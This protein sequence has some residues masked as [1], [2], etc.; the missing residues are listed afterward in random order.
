MFAA[1]SSI[2]LL[3]WSAVDSS[4]I[5]PL[6]TGRRS[7]S[8]T[9]TRT[10]SSF[11]FA[12]GGFGA[13]SSSKKKGKSNKR[14]QK[15]KKGI[16]ADLDFKPS[17]P[18]PLT[19]SSAAKDTD[20]PKLDRFGLPIN[21]TLEDLFP[22][23]R[24]D[25][26]VIPVESADY[27]TK[28]EDVRSIMKEHI[29]LNYDIFDENGVEK[30]EA[31]EKDSGVRN[32]MKLRILHK[33]PPVFAIDNFFTEEE[34]EEYIQ[35]SQSG[36][37]NMKDNVSSEAAL[38][39]D[40]KT[41]AL[42]TATRTSTT[43]FCHYKQ[44]P[45]LLV[46]A[47]RLLDNLPLE[48]MEEPQLVRYR[49]GEQFS[50]HCDEIPA[51][52]LPNGGQRVATLLVYL[53]TLEED[54]GGATVFRDLKDATGKRLGMRPVKGSALLFF[55][56]FANGTPDDRTLHKGEIAIDEKMIGQI[57]VHERLYKPAVPPGNS[58]EA[59]MEV[60]KAKRVELGFHQ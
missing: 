49:T 38:E 45:T 42:S 17:L 40:S 30:I 3:L 7:A 56:A 35:L 39:V 60:V 50:Y 37:K 26:E 24:D 21:P 34:C 46:K 48:R 12:A 41:F 19:D 10:G 36:R 43:W 13:S 57:W 23:L 2:L 20:G 55:P 54:R 25:V 32:P 51:P 1:L 59:A 6:V 22:P 11:A 44:V 47:G 9:G 28:L 27:Q 4:C 5:P 15:T 31:N 8:S 53:K 18:P 52:Q 16:L 29:S 33:S 58:H 14:K